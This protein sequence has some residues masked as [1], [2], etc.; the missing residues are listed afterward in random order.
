MLAST[1]SRPASVFASHIGATRS[2]SVTPGAIALQLIPNGPSS[3]DSLRVRAIMPPL[4]V[5]YALLLTRLKP[6]P[7]MD[8]TLTILPEPCCFMVGTTALVNWNVPLRLKSTRRRH[9]SSDSS[10]MGRDGLAT[11]VLPPTAFT[12]MSMRPRRAQACAAIRVASPSSVTSAG[13]A[14]ALPPALVMRVTSSSSRCRFKS[15]AKTVA[16]SAASNSLLARPMP[17]AAPVTMATCLSNRM[18][19]FSS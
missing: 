6:R 19:A 7:A 9:S 1:S 5:A 4:A 2:V 17:L 11:M 16:P 10:S 3:N 18:R 8:D 12:R 13:I 14:S 15:T